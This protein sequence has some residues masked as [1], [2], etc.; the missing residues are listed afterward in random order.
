[1]P[2]CSCHPCF[3]EAKYLS[4]YKCYSSEASFEGVKCDMNK[5]LHIKT[6]SPTINDAHGHVRLYRRRTRWPWLI[7]PPALSANCLSGSSHP[8]SPSLPLTVC[9]CPGNI[10]DEECPLQINGHYH[11]NHTMSWNGMMLIM[12]TVAV[13]QA[14]SPAL[15]QGQAEVQTPGFDTSV[16]TLI[17]FS[18]R[19]QQ[20]NI[21]T[22]SSRNCWNQSV[23]NAI[24]LS[25]VLCWA[26]NCVYVVYQ[27]STSDSRKL[28]ILGHKG[29]RFLDE[30][31]STLIS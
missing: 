16:L 21:K 26:Q 20:L 9:V 10:G 8:L 30:I 5:S 15:P 4:L 31:R 14:N 13:S 28:D 18:T 23:S 29:I 11:D 7:H 17:S 24:L 2:K 22:H 19:R 27:T 1:M 6:N 12:A 25:T 3:E